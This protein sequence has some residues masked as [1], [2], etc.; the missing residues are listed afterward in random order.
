[1]EVLMDVPAASLFLFLGALKTF[2]S[3]VQ[4]VP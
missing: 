2:G 1:M 3:T 4:V